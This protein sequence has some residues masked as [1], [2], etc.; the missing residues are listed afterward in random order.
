MSHPHA[1]R[2]P[3]WSTVLLWATLC[4]P[5]CGGTAGHESPAPPGQA[6]QDASAASPA[7]PAPTPPAASAVTTVAGPSVGAGALAPRS[8]PGHRWDGFVFH[9]WS[10]E[11]ATY[12]YEWTDL[13]NGGASCSGER[14]LAAVDA[15]TDQFLPDGVIRIRHTQPDPVSGRCDPPDLGVAVEARRSAFLER[16][17]IERP[18]GSRAPIGPGGQVQL[19]S[20]ALTIESRVLDG[21]RDRVWNSGG[22]EGAGLHLQ[23]KSDRLA[24]IVLDDGKTHRAGHWDY[25]P[26]ELITDPDNLFGVVLVECTSVAFEGDRHHWLTDAFRLR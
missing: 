13:G 9:G 26:R 19:G 24:P 20:D 14:G 4:S 11:G 6:G 12:A 23:V 16:F 17:R 2:S 5:A 21:G 25:A 22:K 7:E 15:R 3:K 1:S 8:E 10:R 18:P